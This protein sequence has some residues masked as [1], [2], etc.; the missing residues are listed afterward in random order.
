[1]TFKLKTVLAI[2]LICF[3]CAGAAVVNFVLFTREKANSTRLQSNIRWG[4]EQGFQIIDTYKAKNGQLVARNAVLEI[5]AKELRTGLALDV[6]KHLENL[7]IKPKHITN[8]SETVIKH[9][10]EIVT[11]L[12]DSIIYDTVKARC[13]Q[14]QDKYNRFSG[15]A[16]G[17]VQNVRFLAI[18]SIIQVIYE[19]DRYNRKGK[20]RP[21]CFFWLPLRLDQVITSSNPSSKIIYSKTI[22]IT[23]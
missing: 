19:G 9:E 17:D 8:Y 7:G 4:Y 18:D 5:T 14:Y 12:R 1:M 13:F 2:V 16:A 3:L 21:K 20:K 6:V 10:K 15:C 23:K 22:Q 11:K